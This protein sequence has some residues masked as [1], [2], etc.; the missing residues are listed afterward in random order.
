M[1]GLAPSDRPEVRSSGV[2]PWWTV[3]IKQ[4]I[5][6]GAR[7]QLSQGVHRGSFW[8]PD[9]RGDPPQQ[10]KSVNLV[11]R[12]QLFYRQQFVFRLHS[13]ARENSRAG[14][15]VFFQPQ[16]ESFLIEVV[17][18]TGPNVVTF[19]GASLPVIDAS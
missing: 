11:L 16:L 9:R 1:P 18:R 5:R 14:R 7:R 4:S 17:D 12:T 2:I 13:G 3:A 19:G 6:P 15:C 8:Q 10:E